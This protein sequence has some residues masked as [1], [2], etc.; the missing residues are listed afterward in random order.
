[1]F[2]SKFLNSLYDNKHPGST[3]KQVQI[4]VDRFINEFMNTFGAILYHHLSALLLTRYVFINALILNKGLL[5]STNNGIIC[6][7]VMN[8]WDLNLKWFF[9][10]ISQNVGYITVFL[11]ISPEPIFV[12]K[13]SDIFCQWNLFFVVLLTGYI[14]SPKPTRTQFS[15]PHG[16]FKGD[17]S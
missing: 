11:L 2:I 10:R 15:D 6:Q 17:M 8:E 14:S 1:M 5:K 16:R 12:D 13:I 4:N 7:N 9:F 3:P